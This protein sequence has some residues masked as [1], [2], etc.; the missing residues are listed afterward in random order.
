MADDVST[1]PRTAAQYA[2]VHKAMSSR[3][4]DTLHKPYSPLPPGA[5]F[6]ACGVSADSACVAGEVRRG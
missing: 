1:I 2:E 6:A 3:E 5:C 4:V